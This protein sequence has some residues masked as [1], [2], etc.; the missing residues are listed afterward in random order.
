MALPAV[1]Y[2]LLRRR[3]Y[4]PNLQAAWGFGE[5]SG[6]IA[7]DSSTNASAL[8]VDAGLTWPTGH[9]GGTAIANTGVTASAHATWNTLGTNVT[10]MGWAR[11]LDLTA[12]TIRPLFGIWDSADV[13][14]ASTQFA[15]YAQRSDFS[16]ANVLQGNVRVS[17]GL[18]TANQSALALNTWVHLALTYNGSNIRL[19]RD[20]LEVATNT[21]TGSINAGSFFIVIAPNP[22]VA[23]I[24]DVRMYDIALNED[25]IK[26]AMNNPVA[27]P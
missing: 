24:D 2:T 6:T 5:G 9:S 15:I 23:E 12:S 7:R 21:I 1:R 18:T 25:Q 8:T 13:T 16:T 19:Y 22:G 14:S 26:A 4:A 17:G 20:G 11:P 27:E 3:E 10:L